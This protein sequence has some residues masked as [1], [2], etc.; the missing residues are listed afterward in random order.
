VEVPIEAIPGGIDDFRY[1]SGEGP[2]EFDVIL[3]ARLVPVKRI[4]IFLKVIQA[5]ARELP[6]IRAVIVGDG[7]LRSELE[8]QARQWGIADRVTF[9]GHQTDVASWL[10]RSRIFVLTS[11]SEGLALSIMEAMMSGLPCV[12]SEVGDLGDL[13]HHGRNGWLVPRRQVEQ[14]AG[15][16]VD[17]LKNPAALTALA[18]GA[19][20]AALKVKMAAIAERWTRLLAD[21][22]P[23]ER[24]PA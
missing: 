6:A 23:V 17:L 10:R 3:V 9:A 20:S 13:V 7:P 5:A 22:E 14:Y 24:T 1:Q 21:R 11:D 8:L 15:R 18:A 2:R 12:V 19:R 16:I 4:D